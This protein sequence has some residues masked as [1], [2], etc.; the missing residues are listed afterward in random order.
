MCK[1]F[2]G[3]ELVLS[4]SSRHFGVDPHLVTTPTSVPSPR[5]HVHIINV[6]GYTEGVSLP[7]AA[8]SLNVTVPLL[9]VC[10]FLAFLAR[11]HS[12]ISN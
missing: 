3:E 5:I 1:L 12:K 8:Y 11:L 4:A 6:H 2:E 7:L 10:T 9:P